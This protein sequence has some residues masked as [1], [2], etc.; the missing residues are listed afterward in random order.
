MA[1]EQPHVAAL[2]SQEAL[3]HFGGALRQVDLTDR[4]G[5]RLHWED[6]ECLT[7]FR[8][9]LTRFWVLGGRTMPL[10]P[11]SRVSIPVLDGA[12]HIRGTDDHHLQKTCFLLNLTDQPGFMH[13]ALGAFASREINVAV[14]HPYPRLG[15]AFEYLFF[16]EIEGHGDEP[17]VVEAQ[18]QI[19][20]GMA[21]LPLHQRPCIRL[22]SYPNT[23]F[24]HRYPAFREAFMSRAAACL[25]G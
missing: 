6:V 16:L 8:N 19:N 25:R 20:Q 21:H 4:A 13:R 11:E 23:P 7:D 9:G 14:I 10:V 2:A 18:Q 1:A 17:L 22:G 5:G 12:G 3:D 15:R 24:L